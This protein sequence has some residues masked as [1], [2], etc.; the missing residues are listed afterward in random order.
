MS[1]H[2]SICTHT[3]VHRTFKSLLYAN[4]VT[5]EHF[6]TLVKKYHRVT[7]RGGKACVRD[8][9]VLRHIT[10]SLTGDEQV[11][12][13]FSKLASPASFHPD[14][15]RKV[16]LKYIFR[17]ETMIGCE[18]AS[19]L[20]E[21]LKVNEVQTLGSLRKAKESR[22]QEIKGEVSSNRKGGADSTNSKGKVVVKKNIKRRRRKKKKW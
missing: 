13:S 14:D 10:D 18:I 22:R 21:E 6:D 3:C 15:L 1:I 11:L 2:R 12:S 19:Q 5:H 17:V 7:H 16:F 9:Y 8:R 4:A 20:I